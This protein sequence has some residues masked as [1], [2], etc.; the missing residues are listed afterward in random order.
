MPYSTLRQKIGQLFLIGF[1]GDALSTNN[2]IIADIKEEHLGGVILFDRFLAHR[3]DNHNIISAKQLERLTGDLQKLAGGNLLIAVDQE[4]G[5]VNRFRKERGFPIT[6]TAAE[7]GCMPN[8]EATITSARQ[9]ARMLRAAG[10]NFNLAPVVDINVNK[11]NPIIGRYGRSFSEN[12]RTVATHAAAWINEHRKEGIQ[13]C[14]KH[15][16]GHG[17]SDS[18]SHLGFVDLSLS[19]CKSELEP[20]RLL[21][22]SG[23]AEAIMVGH[24]MNRNLDTTYPATLS[25]ATLHGLLREEL[26]FIG[27]IVSDDMQMK[28]IT[29]HYGLE[30]ACCKSLAAGIDLLIIGNNLMYDHGILPKIKDAIEKAVHRG[31]ISE[32]RIEEAFGFVQKFKLS[33][34]KPK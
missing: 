27:L 5:K 12:G 24:L 26:R 2:P 31:E 23:H 20:Y 6:A 33:L 15:F 30:E 22:D 17:S 10:V 14:L 3:Q 1:A 9:T 29:N 19:W 21:I 34:S 18:D 25:R 16:P 13:C 11:D 32:Q 7:L 4:G 8:I 28:A